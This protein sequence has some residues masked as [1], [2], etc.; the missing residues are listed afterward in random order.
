MSTKRPIARKAKSAIKAEVN[1]LAELRARI[2]QVDRDIQALINER[3]AFARQIGKAK[4]PLKAAIDYYRPER[5][6]QVLRRVIER[7]HGPLA[8]EELVRLFREIMS[9]CLAQQDPLRIAFLGPEGTFTHTALLK[10]FGHSVRAL[11]MGSIEEVF[12]EV[13]NS[14]ADF[15][16]VPV[17]NSSEGSVH[18]TQDM[19][20]SSPLHIC[21]EI[22][23]RIQ[24]NLLA[25]GTDLKSI[26]RV[27]AHA[28]SLAQCR[29]WL[30]K[31]LPKAE[32]IAVSSNAEAARRSRGMTEAAAIAGDAAAQVYG[33]NTLAA[34]IEDR[35]DNST[36]FVVLGR[37]LFSASGV[38]KTSLML[39]AKDQPGAL[40]QLLDP[41][42]RNGVSMTRIESRPSKQKK[43][44][45]VFFIDVEGHIED[46][47]LQAALKDLGPLAKQI[48]ILGSYP[49]AVL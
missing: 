34:H 43:W 2:D 35:P 24:Q 30:R 20:L 46:P 4:G 19:F 42:A 3:A 5:E 31:H 25:S 22:E 40:Y 28:Q 45:Y 9:A 1:P 6:A 36:R 18:H 29:L 32:R 10:H 27:Y 17:E 23:L 49:Q 41:L 38:D 26:E 13:E 16:V 11:A 12:A 14:N 44:E 39:A 48:K 7:N 8:N 33:L 15:G 21:G 37:E 47:K